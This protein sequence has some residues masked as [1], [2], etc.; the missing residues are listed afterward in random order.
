MTGGQGSFFDSLGT[1]ETLV[2]ANFTEELPTKTYQL[3]VLK[4]TSEE[5]DEHTQYLERLKKKGRCLWMD[6]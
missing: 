6:E 5:I 1:A 3:S 4:A 2:K